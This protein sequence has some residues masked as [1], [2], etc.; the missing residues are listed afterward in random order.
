MIALNKLTEIK[1]WMHRNAREVEL[2]LWNY[3]F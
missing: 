2:S 1:Y 3:F